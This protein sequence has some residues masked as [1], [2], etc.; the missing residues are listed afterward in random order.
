MK[1]DFVARSSITKMIG[2][3][4]GGNGNCVNGVIITNLEAISSRLDQ[5]ED[6][7]SFPLPD[8]SR[9]LPPGNRIFRQ[10]V[11]KSRKSS[12]FEDGMGP[13]SFRIPAPNCTYPNVVV[14]TLSVYVVVFYRYARLGLE[15]TE[16]LLCR[17]VD[18][19][20]M[21]L[22]S[23]ASNDFSLSDRRSW[24]AC[25]VCCRYHAKFQSNLAQISR[26]AKAK[27]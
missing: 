23:L 16:N 17:R 14:P 15:L 24:P 2:S 21:A 19:S 5:S 25:R 22:D 11:F 6:A 10:L 9:A 26:V 8:P 3:A 18:G 7:P 27:R 13:R 12:P 1:G 20:S 4:I